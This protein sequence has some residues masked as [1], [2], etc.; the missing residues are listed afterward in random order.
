[1]LPN[2]NTSQHLLP[3][4]DQTFYQRPSRIVGLY[5]LEGQSINTFVSCPAVLNTMREEH[6]DLV[7]SLFNT[8]MT[9]GRAAHMYSPAQYQ[10][11]THPAI[12]PTPAL[13]GQVYR[14][15]WHPHFVGSLLSSFSNYSIARLAHQKFQEV[16]D[17]D[18]H[19]L[20]ITFK[21]GDMYLF[22]NFLILH[23]REKVLE[24]P[25]T[26]VG[27][28]VPEQTVLDGWR[29]LL[30]LNL[31][32]V[33]EERWLTHMPLVQLYELNKMVHG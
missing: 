2:F 23:G 7:D 30:T 8:P 15:C 29:E 17:R 21:P 12:I 14:F 5:C 13:P 6:P 26:S 28:S 24:V 22:D 16:M 19:Q 27:Q 32:G 25:R 11:A 18:T 4:V 31:M 10:G 9:F 3:H 20:R 1:M 33:M